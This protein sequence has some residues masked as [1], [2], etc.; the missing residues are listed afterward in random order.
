MKRICVITQC[1]LPIP[2]SKGGAVE[3]LAEY[4]INENERTPKYLFTVITVKDNCSVELARRYKYTEFVFIDY[5]DNRI[6]DRCWNI[7]YRILKHSYIYIPFSRS[8]FAALM[9]IKKLEKHDLYLYLAGPTTQIPIL[10]RLIDKNRLLVHLHWDGMGT[11]RYAA[12]C[13]RVIAISRYIKEQWMKKTGSNEVT[14]VENC[15]N[16]DLFDKKVT[17]IEK[18]ELRNKLGIHSNN[19]VILFVGRIIE[20][21]GIRELIYAFQKIK[22]K[23]TVLLIIGGSNFGMKTDTPFEKEISD[24][25]M[26]SEKKIIFTGY[27]HQSELYKY[28]SLA[29]CSVMPSQFQEPAGLV[30]IE[31]QATGTPL[32]VTRVGGLS[33]YCSHEAT[34]TVEKDGNQVEH[35]KTAIEFLLSNPG[36]CAI[37]GEKGREFAKKYNTISF[38]E[39]LS[40]I[41][42]L[43]LREAESSEKQ[44]ERKES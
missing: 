44:Q 10:A 16:L 36:K 37:M 7:I 15:V 34:I 13:K 24:L 28:Y 27:I 8:F 32:I 26:K 39:G 2:T 18:T 6:I 41:F 43:T 33:E 11:P 22:D 30:A 3:T 38:F 23:D 14:V 29:D 5:K 20:A 12:S 9:A 1:S 40:G 25:I 31:A 21:K 4:M 35:I 19:K 42:D 17:E